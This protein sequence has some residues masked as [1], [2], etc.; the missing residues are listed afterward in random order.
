MYFKLLKNDFKK[1][2]GK[3]LILLLF[4]SLAVMLVASVFLMLTQLFTS[5]SSMYEKAKPPHFLQMHKGELRQESI[6]AF[7]STYPGLEYWQTVPMTDVYGENLIVRKKEENR[8]FS[9]EDCRLDI[10]LVKQN[11]QYDV[12]LDKDRN[13]L[14]MEEGEIG[15][16]V[17]LLEKYSIEVGD[18]IC[19]KGEEGEKSFVVADYV[20][21]GQMNSTLCSSTRFLISEADFHD[22][23]GKVGEKEY[24]I[25]AYFEDPS[26]AAD[27]QSAYEQSEKDLPRDGQAVTYTMIFLLSAMT[28]IMTA[29]VFLLVGILLILIAVICLRYTILAR[30]EEDVEQIGTMKAMGIPGK[31]IKAL[32]LGEIRILMGMGSAAGYVAALGTVRLL[33]GHMSRTFGTHRPQGSMYI[34]AVGICVLVYGIILLF[35]GK[36]LGRLDQVTVTDLL[37][38]EKGF[39]KTKMVRNGIHKSRY[40]PVNLLVGLHEAGNGYGII[41][42]LMLIVSFL[43]TVPYRMVHTME[44]KEFATYMGSPVCDV[45]IEVEQGENLTERKERTEKLLASEK[46]QEWVSDYR[47][48]RRVRLQAENQEGELQGIHIDTGQESGTG[49]RYLTGQAPQGEGEVALSSL[50]ADQLGKK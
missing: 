49:I 30:M 26:M 15:V 1:N 11:Q 34:A 48:L 31:G 35:A 19:L 10:S 12:L 16:P 43:V 3:H 24:L 50:M 18:E 29:M 39:G 9:L 8:E 4:M 25:E 42:C 40:L 14:H 7:N 22:L 21:D 36:V 46:E 23:F 45:L 44:D 38:T 28:D 47:V 27:Y 6:D 13:E 33:T 37:V 2:P 32:Y 20:Y 5:V 41:F 17:I